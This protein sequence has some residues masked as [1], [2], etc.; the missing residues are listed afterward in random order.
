MKTKFT[1]GEWSVSVESGS[2]KV[3]YP[4]GFLTSANVIK[5]D[6]SRLDGE[7][8]LEMRKRTDPAREAAMAESNA[9][10]HLISCAPEMYDILDSIEN[11]NNQVPEFLWEKI[12]SV[13]AKAR[14]EEC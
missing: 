13:L 5:I 11:D 4:H 7:S 8:W 10:M 6:E 3:Y 9:N 1:K 2:A 12:Q 14:G